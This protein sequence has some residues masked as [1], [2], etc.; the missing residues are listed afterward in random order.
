MS[1]SILARAVRRAR[2]SLEPSLSSMKPSLQP[3]P[4]WIFWA[5][6]R[7]PFHCWRELDLLAWP[8]VSLAISPLSPFLTASTYNSLWLFSIFSNSPNKFSFAQ[9]PVSLISSKAASHSAKFAVLSSCFFTIWSFTPVAILPTSSAISALIRCFRASPPSP[10]S[11]T[12][13]CVP[14][15]NL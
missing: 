11:N 7:V 1:P 13:F 6:S 4:L 2:F 12:L 15:D 3:T 8:F 5:A 14:C 10:A 9:A